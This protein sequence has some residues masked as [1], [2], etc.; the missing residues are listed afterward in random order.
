[1]KKNG[2]KISEENRLNKMKKIEKIV[3]RN[4]GKN[5]GKLRKIGKKIGLKKSR[6]K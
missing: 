6:N 5:D 3:Q 1:M 4:R 2:V